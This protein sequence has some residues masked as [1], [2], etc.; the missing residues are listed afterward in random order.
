MCTQKLVD[1][2]IEL[3]KTV[4]CYYYYKKNITISFNNLKYYKEIVNSLFYI[5][6]VQCTAI[7]PFTRNHGIRVKEGITVTAVCMHLYTHHSGSSLC[8]I[9]LGSQ[10][11]KL[12]E[13]IY[14]FIYYIVYFHWAS[15]FSN[16]ALNNFHYL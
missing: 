15:Q 13:Y 16:S 1:I 11:V 9:R 7:P 4:Q 14:L 10:S 12:F 3:F 5:Y 8:E 6:V 2:L